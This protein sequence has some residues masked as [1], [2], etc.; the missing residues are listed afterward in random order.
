MYNRL[1]LQTLGYQS[2]MSQK[3]TRSLIRFLKE[4]DLQCLWA[5]RFQMWIKGN[6]HAPKSE[7]AD[8]FFHLLQKVGKELPS[9][10]ACLNR[11]TIKML[12]Y[13]TRKFE[14]N[15]II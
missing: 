12:I 5:P 2:I 3:S 7:C 6:D 4:F 1:E 15:I 9:C 10:A 8:F 14:K 13:K 11:L